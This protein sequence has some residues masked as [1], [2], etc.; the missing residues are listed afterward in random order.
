MEWSGEERSGGGV[1]C[2]NSSRV[3]MAHLI[4]VDDDILNI[5]G[6]CNIPD[7]INSD[8]DGNG[9][10]SQ[11]QG[12]GQNE[13]QN[14]SH[15]QQ[16]GKSAVVG[17]EEG[18]E[19]GGGINSTLNSMAMLNDPNLDHIQTL[20]GNNGTS[21]NTNNLSLL[22]HPDGLHNHTAQVEIKD[23]SSN[24]VKPTK[25]KKVPK[26]NYTNPMVRAIQIVERYRERGNVVPR[27][28]SSNLG[29]QE[30][31]QEHKDAKRIYDWKQAVRGIGKSRCTDEIRA[32]LDEH[33]PTWNDENPR[34]L[35]GKGN[36]KNQS[37]EN[38]AVNEPGIDYTSVN[39]SSSKDSNTSG[40]KRKQ[41]RREEAR[42]Q[43]MY[44]RHHPLTA[45]HTSV[46]GDGTGIGGMNIMQMQMQMQMQPNMQGH[47]YAHH[48]L[49]PHQHHQM[50]NPHQHQQPLQHQHAHDQLQYQLHHQQ[51]HQ[52]H[53]HQ[54]QH[55]HQ[56]QHH[57]MM[58]NLG[59][60]Q[61]EADEHDQHARDLEAIIAT[62]QQDHSSMG[63]HNMGHHDHDLDS[64]ERKRIRMTGADHEQYLIAPGDDSL[65]VASGGVDDD[66]DDV[67]DAVQRAMED[68]TSATA[69]TFAS[70]NHPSISGRG[71]GDGMRLRTDIGNGNG[72]MVIM[73]VG[74]ENSEW[75]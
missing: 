28:L 47:S 58:L 53:Q 8:S 32:Y 13:C 68:F 26:K 61:H 36:K 25:A 35:F 59:V 20:N 5:T 1:E 38:N 29:N 44:N 2:E 48:L 50:Q 19:A 6:R 45:D 7:N 62:T 63:G 43:D 12:H 51:L 64:H 42:E 65:D 67:E 72:G 31:C 69:S 21:N 75:I 14:Q 16:D 18:G 15:N 54:L 17:G 33:M 60:P 49:R 39:K 22:N 74:K 52:Q 71:D 11:H 66:E 27:L 56:H 34:S 40:N 57:H 30:R 4:N 55:Q 23:S 46:S 9:N 37:S 73:E 24:R 70:M 10:Q 41:K 3:T